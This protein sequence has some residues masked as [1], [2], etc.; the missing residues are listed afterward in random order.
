MAIQAD[1]TFNGLPVPNA[2]VRATR[3]IFTSK[4]NCRAY[5]EVYVSE[6]MANT[7]STGH[8]VASGIPDL[9]DFKYDYD[10]DLSLHAQAYN[11]AKLLPEFADAI[12]V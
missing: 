3:F 5:I 8:L 9:V 6:E 1:I 7:A 2:Y 10:S 4:T 11:A 12:D